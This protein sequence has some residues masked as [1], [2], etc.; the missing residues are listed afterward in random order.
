M[1]AKGC[2]RPVNAAC[3]LEI[4]LLCSMEHRKFH[5][6]NVLTVVTDRM[7][8]PEGMDGVRSL[9][10]Y[11]VRDPLFDFQLPN[12]LRACRADILKQYPAMGNVDASDINEHNLA[13]WLDIQ[14][15]TFGEM[16]EIQPLVS[17]WKAS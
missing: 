1:N 10:E 6:G 9:L 15:V 12:A 16:V 17:G 4:L 3:E 14:S 5:I 2:T 13:V 11:M 7:V 8:S